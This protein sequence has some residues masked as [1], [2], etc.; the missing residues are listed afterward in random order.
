MRMSLPKGPD[1][2]ESGQEQRSARLPDGQLEPPRE[3][4]KNDRNR[5]EHQHA[6]SEDN[7]S[8]PGLVV[9]QPFSAEDDLGRD[10][11]EHIALERTH[12]KEGQRRE[13]KPADEEM[14]LQ[15]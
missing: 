9:L 15:K 13:Q 10:Q 12:E 14:I 8:G 4:A 3:Q 5:G 2:N 11:R 7:C 6:H 1:N